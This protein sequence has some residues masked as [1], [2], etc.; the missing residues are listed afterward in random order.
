MHE[1]ARARATQEERDSEFSELNLGYDNSYGAIKTRHEE[2]VRGVHRQFTCIA[3]DRVAVGLPAIDAALPPPAHV[4]AAAK[5]SD[6]ATQLQGLVDKGET[7]EAEMLAQQLLEPRLL[8]ALHHVPPSEMG[9]REAEAMD[10]ANV[11]YMDLLRALAADDLLDAGQT[12][13]R[14]LGV[15]VPLAKGEAPYLL[16]IASRAGTGPRDMPD[17]APQLAHAVVELIDTLAKTHKLGKGQTR[18]DVRADMRRALL[19]QAHPRQTVGPY[20]KY[21]DFHGRILL[22]GS[23]TT[24]GKGAR[25]AARE[26]AAAQLLPTREEISTAGLTSVR[27]RKFDVVRKMAGPAPQSTSRP[28]PAK[29]EELGKVAR[30][31]GQLNVAGAQASDAQL[32][33]QQLAIETALQLKA[34]ARFSIYSAV[35][36]AVN[37]QWVAGARDVRKGFAPSGSA[38]IL[39]AV[40][41]A[42]RANAAGA[43]RATAPSA[44]T[45]KVCD[46][47]LATTEGQAVLQDLIKT[48]RR[49]AAEG[50]PEFENKLR[51]L[52]GAHVQGELAP[53]ESRLHRQV[54]A[55]LATSRERDVAEW[56]ARQ[57]AHDAVMAQDTLRVQARHANQPTATHDATT[58]QARLAQR[59]NPQTQALLDPAPSVP[60]MAQ[61]EQRRA[62]LGSAAESAL[63]GAMPAVPHGPVGAAERHPAGSAEGRGATPSR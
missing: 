52:A 63:L 45:D 6:I 31:L 17:T 23:P 57:Q 38:V 9:V 33:R 53:A 46:A 8:A 44:L 55:T 29:G 43:L 16:H 1:Q 2:G 60:R 59:R 19:T 18:E 22:G 24:P 58:P 50:Y 39:D 12:F 32:H 4:I 27:A 21:I 40:A 7:A 28:V 5:V 25:R 30:T 47:L 20:Q 10:I 41:A 49:Y 35:H 13:G 26:L 37:E 54:R 42:A 61:L 56:T 3:M 14:L 34:E 15:D 48:R 62:G 36:S 51:Q 11:Q